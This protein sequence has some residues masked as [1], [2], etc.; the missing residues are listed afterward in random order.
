[1]DF[2]L[3]NLPAMVTQIMKEQIGCTKLCTMCGVVCDK[4]QGHIGKC[5]S[6]NHKYSGLLGTIFNGHG[7]LSI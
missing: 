4:Q 7:G 1:M 5:E 2:I 3:D 6:A